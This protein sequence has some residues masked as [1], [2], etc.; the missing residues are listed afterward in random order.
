M[1]D[2]DVADGSR[3]DD[4]RAGPERCCYAGE[5]VVERAP[6]GAGW[7]AV[8]SHRVLAY[9]PT[10]DGRR[11]ESVHRPNVAGIAVDV[12]GDAR[13]LRWAIRVAVYGV[14][15][16][17]GG[18]ALRGLDLAATMSVDAGAGAGATAP[19]GGVMSVVNLL[20]GAFAA[21][22]TLLLVVGGLLLAA[23]ALLGV[24]YARTRRPAL[25][26]ERFGDDP[27]RLAASRSDG[28]RAA[29]RLSAALDAARDE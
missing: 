10:A 25:L 9:D 13:L 7:A 1:T 11:F 27:I 3:T 12:R 23:G 17:V 19:L 2:G 22:A 8:T 21:L 14:G 4:E 18:V 5:A 24:Q 20:A 6:L 15:G 26:V 16:L 29:T 28:Q